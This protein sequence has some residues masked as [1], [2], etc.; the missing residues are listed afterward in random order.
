MKKCNLLALA[1]L[2]V[3]MSL[4]ANA[5]LFVRG[6]AG[7]GVGTP[8]DAIGVRNVYAN[9][10]AAPDSLLSQEVIYGSF[11]GGTNAR[12]EVGYMF[13]ENFGLML[14]LAY[15]WGKEIT[16]NENLN[17]NNSDHFYRQTSY[18]RQ[19][20]L[21][22]QLM[23]SAGK[24]KADGTLKTISP[25]STFGILMP[26]SGGSFGFSDANET[27]LVT[28][29]IKTLRPDAGD[30]HVE[31][32]IAGTPTFGFQASFGVDVNITNNLS[33]FVK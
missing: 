15:L 28:P 10:F 5:Q 33:A 7:Y 9:G 14:G 4:S 32:L 2:L 19:V 26:V 31:A 29:L 6:S 17:A 13:N 24:T 20:R 11:G 16:I 23:V 8:A 18:T 3:G 22:P 27:N 1:I 12:L 25:Y 30:F 21:L